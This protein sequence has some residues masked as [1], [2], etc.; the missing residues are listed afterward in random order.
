MERLSL[1]SPL[2]VGSSYGVCYRDLC[3]SEVKLIVW[4]VMPDLC[5]SEVELYGECRR[6]LCQSEIEVVGHASLPYLS[7]L[8]AV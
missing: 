7:E 3:Q 1:P 2:S 6:D 4:C 5:R 8:S